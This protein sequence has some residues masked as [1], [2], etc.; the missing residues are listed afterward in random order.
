L[1]RSF[2]LQSLVVGL[3]LIFATGFNAT[4]ATTDS[5]DAVRIICQ[6][7][8]DNAVYI[9]VQVDQIKAEKVENDDEVFDLVL[10]GDEP[11]IEQAG[12]P[13]LPFI[14]RSIL[15]PPEADFLLHIDNVTSHYRMDLNPAP[16]RSDN[17]DP[18][19]SSNALE[20]RSAGIDYVNP[21]TDGFWPSEPVIVGEP[22]IL[23]GYRILNFRVH[24]VQYNLETGETRINDKIEFHFSSDDVNDYDLANIRSSKP[25]IYAYRAVRHLVEN[26]PNEPSRDELLSASYL[27]IV[28]N[29]N[30]IDEVIA[31]LIEWRKRQ[32]HKVHVEH[33]PN[34]TDRN[35]VTDLIRDA[36]AW[37]DPVEF[38][39]LV[40]DASRADFNVPAATNTGDY[41]YTLLDGNDPLPDVAIGRLSCTDLDQLE[42]IVNKLVSYESNPV[43]D[44]T[45]WFKQGAVIAGATIN[46][47]STILV[48]K[49]VL[50]ELYNI[51]FNDVRH[52]YH[53][54]NGN[55]GGNQP[56]LTDAV[57]WGISVLHYRAYM[58][59]NSLNQNVIYNMGNTQGRWPAVLAISC[60]TGEFVNGNCH[61]EAFLRSRGGGIGAIG[62]AT[63]QTRPQQNNIMSGGVWRGIYKDKLYAFGWG[64]NMGKYE[65]WRAYHGLDGG[66]YSNFM[67]WNNLMGDPGTHV[68]TDIPYEV[69]VDHTEFLPIGSSY[70]HVH[71]IN[72]E[73]E[74]PETNALVCLYKDDELHE[75]QYTNE[76]GQIE[77]VID[78]EAL[79]EG[80]ML[81]TVTKH[82]MLPYLGEIEV[83]QARNYLGVS[84][85]S[86]DDDD[87]G[88]S[89]GNN[90]GICNPDERIELTVEISNL[91]DNVPEA[92][93]TVRMIALSPW[94]EVLSDPVE[95][96]EVPDPD[97][98]IPLTLLFDI[99]PTC[100]DLNGLVFR[101][102]ARNANHTWRSLISPEVE[103]PHVEINALE[104]IG[105]DLGPGDTRDLNIVLNNIGRQRLDAAHAVLSTENDVIAFRRDEADYNPI[106]PN[107]NGDINGQLFRLQANPMTIPGMKVNLTLTLETEDGFHDT[108]AVEIVIGSPGEHDPFGPDEYGYVC[109]DSDDEGWDIIPVYEW[110]EI[111]PE[112]DGHV[113]E[114]TDTGLEDIRDNRDESIAMPL[115]FD[116]QYYGEVFDTITICTNGWAA[117][118]NQA[119]L[120]D[121]RNRRIG[122]ALGP[123]A[124]LCIWWDNLKTEENSAI[125]TYYDE[126]EGR[127]I[128]EWSNVYRLVGRDGR[129]ALETFQII[130][131]DTEGRPTYTNDGII[132]YQYKDAT[133]ENRTA[134]NDTPYCT[135][136][137][138]NLDDSGGIEYSYWNEY[139]DGA[140]P[141]HDEMAITFTTASSFVMGVIQGTVTDY[142]SGNRIQNAVITTSRRFSAETD[143]NG[144]YLIDILIGEN[145]DVTA[146]ADGWLDSTLA[147]F[148]VAEDETLTVNFALLF[149]DFS[150]SVRRIEASLAENTSSRHDL[151][152]TNDGNGPLTWSVERN[153]REGESGIGNRITSYVI[154]PLLN[155]L[156]LESVAFVDDRFYVSGQ[157]G[158]QPNLIYVLD[159]EGNYITRFQQVGESRVGMT[160]LTYGN[161][162]IW[163]SGEQTIYGFNT[164]GN[165]IES[166]RGP[167]NNNK[168]LAFDSNLNVIWVTYTSRPIVAI[169][170]EGNRITALDSHWPRI[171]GMA[172]W[173]DDP[174][175]FNLYIANDAGQNTVHVSK[176]NTESNDTM[177]VATLSTN[178][179][180]QPGGV[181]LA[182]GFSR[183]GTVF[184]ILMNDYLNQQGDRIDIWQ[185]GSYKGW[186]CLNLEEGVIE[187]ESS[188]DLTLTLDASG[189]FPSTYEGELLFHHTARGGETTI[190]VVL[191]VYDLE[192][193]SGQTLQPLKFGI[194]TAY[195]NPF[196]A[197]TLLKYAVSS[198]GFVRLVVY[199]LQ[200][201]E[202]EILYEGNTV[203]GRYATEVNTGN[204]ASGIYLV[205]LEAG[206]E[207]DLVKL[208]CV[209]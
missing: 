46:G 181:F 17:N 159:E 121:F 25:S 199:D 92:P 171:S 115:P 26:P 190:D 45:D 91:G 165:L 109:F 4:L 95:L 124:Q 69:E 43:M 90:N 97:E 187:P 196:N 168:A 186:M 136:G 114:G 131:F 166:F 27:Y 185:V 111:N 191:E 34:N 193:E 160:D 48:A 23:R 202:M 155:D 88:E 106:N 189:L 205:R 178:E 57:E 138:S 164:T 149:T 128:I 10:I 134:H 107:T 80:T 198:P 105:G 137:I 7:K 47:L 28:P 207:V 1:L 29:Y 141:I 81:I 78:P 18:S 96:D 113:F 79:S 62:T 183:Y 72:L 173:A 151:S 9:Y 116:F 67:D 182:E 22:A 21:D 32:G 24:P 146:S 118:G 108:A 153:F 132:T 127:F 8:S 58:N 15:I 44:N 33:V 112:I 188:Q 16:A 20:D 56:F 133:N 31:P 39:A 71:V 176:I 35:R 130:L 75:T 19:N 94:A 2:S 172:Y 125:L 129:G 177:F 87:N 144:N 123:E 13:V 70:I 208:V 49:Y 85:W 89:H 55:I 42:R 40:G 64:L 209:K 179:I 156:T 100:P 3:V 86:I 82:N 197:A 204:W 6:T 50:K 93:F 101:I 36:Y 206:G 147:G 68:W 61:S 41:N 54:V 195:P 60:A 140:T 53:D 167:Y 11:C 119:E 63:M 184:M 162:L 145:Y 104:F 139:A 66:A 158:Q 175:G 200:G 12:R 169:D 163:G 52:W 192:I 174:D 157:N 98:S 5:G 170:L 161:G 203:A 148:D 65:L 73:D 142:A 143:I 201:R 51:G 126:E 30:G 83:G 84:E 59:M 37:D 135:I 122:Q 102:E 38:V 152:I 76:D 14:A 180:G 77:F 103:A 99:D 194:E 150:P 154:A 117:F 120:C 110:I 74:E